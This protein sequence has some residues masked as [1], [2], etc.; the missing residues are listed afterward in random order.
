MFPYRVT[1]PLWAN[2]SDSGYCKVYEEL[3]FIFINTI[4]ILGGPN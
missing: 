2:T 1:K 3:Y 4:A